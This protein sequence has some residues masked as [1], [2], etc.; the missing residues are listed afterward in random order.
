MVVFLPMAELSVPTGSAAHVIGSV[1]TKV[2]VM[3]EHGVVGAL[4]ES[5][6]TEDDAVTTI[7]VRLLPLARVV[8]M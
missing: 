1:M 5:S 2:C 3:V 7:A 6:W 4:A 8:V